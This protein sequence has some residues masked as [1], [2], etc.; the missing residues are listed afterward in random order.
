MGEFDWDDVRFFLAIVRSGRL[1][2]AAKRMGVDH[3]TLSRRIAVLETR[4]GTRLFDR[5]PTGFV[6]TPEGERLVVDAEAMESAAIQMR[7]RVD[8]T[9]IGVGGIVR[10]GTPE[11]FG[12]YFLAPRL[13]KLIALYPELEVELV[14]VPR[15]FNLSRR[16]A[17]IAVGMAR[18]TQGRVYAHKL[19][20][21][22]LG[23]YAASSYVD[24]H[25]PVRS[26]ADLCAHTWIGYVGD[27]KWTDELDYLGQISSE[28]EPGVRI[29][30]V[31]TQMSALA[32]GAGL[33]I[34][35]CFMART[36]PGL[37][38]V[39]PDV[40]LVRSYWLISHA[41]THHFA[42]VRLVSDFI[43]EESACAKSWWGV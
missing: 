26:T 41:D 13:A 15:M 6:L 5:R 16:E 18:P 36:A 32:A 17:D 35:P 37:R 43:R 12:T 38:R 30:N 21:F 29:S 40:A 25:A 19:A 23:I 31:I 4:L 11:G 2:T 22:S 3:S 33:G 10:L 8:D 42:R 1:T 14:A 20:D 24:T 7:A 39:L 9:S 28:L 27:L 34:V